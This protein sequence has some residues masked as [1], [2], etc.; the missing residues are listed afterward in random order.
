MGICRGL[1]RVLRRPVAHAA[2][3]G[4]AMLLVTSLAGAAW[5]MP[6]HSPWA[7]AQKVDEIGG[8][9]T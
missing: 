7:Q 3:V 1:T 9:S 2:V 4:G 6:A 5:A 8:N